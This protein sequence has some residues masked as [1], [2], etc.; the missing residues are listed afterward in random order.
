ME[1]LD[2]GRAAGG[3][4]S[5]GSMERLEV[6]GADKGRLERLSLS[7]WVRGW[8]MVGGQCEISGRE[9]GGTWVSLEVMD[10]TLK[11]ILMSKAPL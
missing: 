1:V 8:E 4:D 6:V 3:L 11:P 9:G 10:G 7:L 5:R 2:P